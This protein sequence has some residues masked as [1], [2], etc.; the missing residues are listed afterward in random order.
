MVPKIKGVLL[1]CLMI[2]LLLLIQ[3]C[4]GSQETDETGYILLMGF[5]KGEKDILKVTYQMAIPHPVEGGE[6]E[7]QQKLSV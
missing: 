7:K 4:W 1:L 6:A 3:G 2:P 5:D